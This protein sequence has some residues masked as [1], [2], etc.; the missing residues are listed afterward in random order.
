MQRPTVHKCKKCG[1][2]WGHK[3]PVPCTQCELKE[4][5]KREK[6]KNV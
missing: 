1:T 4:K 2:Y 6:E 3:V 5:E